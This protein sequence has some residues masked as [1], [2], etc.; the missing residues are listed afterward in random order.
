MGSIIWPM[1]ILDRQ[2]TG[3]L[4]GLEALS[5]RPIATAVRGPSGAVYH[6]T[7]LFKLE[8]HHQPRKLAIHIIE[9]WLFE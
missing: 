9:N 1:A 5:R 8:P 4:P 2:A 6:S 3:L 7:S